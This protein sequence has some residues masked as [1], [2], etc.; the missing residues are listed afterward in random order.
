MLRR[1]SR[2]AL[3]RLRYW[4]RPFQAP[5]WGTG[6]IASES[7]RVIRLFALLHHHMIRRTPKNRTATRPCA[8][9]GT[10]TRSSAKINVPRGHYGLVSA[11][12]AAA[13]LRCQL[14]DASRRC[15]KLAGTTAASTT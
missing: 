5:N 1:T 14:R 4:L 11:P 12:G 2:L 13:G 10:T 6:I 7:L 15:A 9:V 8:S 3:S